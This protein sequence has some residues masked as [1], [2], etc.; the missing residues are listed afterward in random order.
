MNEVESKMNILLE[1]LGLGYSVKW[2]PNEN[3]KHG[4]ILQNEKIIVIFD[5]SE[6]E[7]WNTIIHE[8]LELKLQ[9]L[10]SYYRDLVNILISFI[11]DHIY[12]EKERFLEVLPSDVLTVMKFIEEAKRK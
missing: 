9:P 2:I 8:I 1:R 6:D 7:A 3:M 11:E 4:K 12:R 10:L 5:K